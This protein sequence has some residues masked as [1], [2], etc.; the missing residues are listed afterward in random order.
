MIW[1]TLCWD[2]QTTKGCNL[3]ANSMAAW[4]LLG[5]C[6]CT[7]WA[8]LTG[9]HKHKVFPS[10]WQQLLAATG[11]LKETRYHT[12]NMGVNKVLMLC[13]FELWQVTVFFMWNEIF[14]ESAR[15]C[16]QPKQ[17]SSLCSIV[18]SFIQFPWSLSK[19][20]TGTNP[21][22]LNWIG[23]NPVPCSRSKLMTCLRLSEKR[24]SVQIWISQ[25][26]HSEPLQMMVC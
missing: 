1:V 20:K 26:S 13:K 18:W 15:S 2:Y 21:N 14:M 25:H 9:E 12:C 19:T 3:A 22:V 24:E 23:M 8:C 7:T 6:S 4:E 17:C 11:L 5:Q 16:Y 10:W